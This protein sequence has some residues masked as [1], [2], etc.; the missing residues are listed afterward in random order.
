MDAN[1]DTPLNPL[2]L[3]P[4]VPALDNTFGAV[5][6]GTFV[7]LVLYG[8]TLHQSYRYFRMYPGDSSVLKGLVIFVL[9]LETFTSAL[10]LHV[11]YYYL[12]TSYFNPLA[13]LSG[14]WSINLFPV[15]S[16]I[17]MTAS[18]SFFARRVWVLGPRYRILVCIAAILCILEIGFFAAAT[19]E[20][21]I[22]PTFEGFKR[23]TWLVST[24]STMAVTADIL[25]TVVLIYVLKH[26]RTGVKRTDSMLDI[27]IMYS[28]N[29][30]LLTGVFNLLSLLFAYIR[31][32]D[33]IYIGIGIPGTKMY[34]NT[35]L[36]ALNSRMSLKEKCSGPFIETSPFS[37]S[38]KSG[39]H[40]QSQGNP[41]V[42]RHVNVQDSIDPTLTT[43]S[44]ILELST[45]S[46]WVCDG[47]DGEIISDLERQD[48]K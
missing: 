13:L 20:A 19:A 47:V 18:Q 48:V 38:M 33:L 22:I 30:G 17:V 40:A 21:F 10:S 37:L 41:S 23:V 2:A 39:I 16:G 32:G 42:P 27:M 29:T 46:Q 8:L 44:M 25:L 34:A 45:K 9:I 24:G 35:L 6:L 12:V 5:L 28:I 3:L 15:V 26:N 11:C 1:P 36:A 7:G 14:T 4:K 31:P 43:D